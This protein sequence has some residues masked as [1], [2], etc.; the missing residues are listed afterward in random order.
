MGFKL[1]WISY[2]LLIHEK[3]LNFR[4]GI[5]QKYKP[6]KSSQLPKLQNFK[7]LKITNHIGLDWIVLILIILFILLCVL[8]SNAYL[9][10]L[11][12]G[13]LLLECNLFRVSKC[14]V[15]YQQHVRL[16]LCMCYCI[17]LAMDQVQVS[18]SVLHTC[19]HAQLPIGY[20]SEE[21]SYQN[22]TL[23]Y[24]SNIKTLL[25]CHSLKGKGPLK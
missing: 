5:L 9:N 10:C 8:F 23:K 1:L 21:M 20:S 18:S 11:D 25:I 6:T 15:S 4:V 14:Q 22:E 12:N 2:T 7:L 13:F 16:W 24:L 19:V 3:V 17:Q